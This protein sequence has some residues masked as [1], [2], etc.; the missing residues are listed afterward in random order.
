MGTAQRASAA[1]SPI[2]IDEKDGT[3][4]I[5]VDHLEDWIGSE[6]RSAGGDK[7][8]KI[9]DIHYAGDDAVAIVIRSG[10]GGRKHH[11]ASLKG[12]RAVRDGINLAISEDDLVTIDGGPL[13]SSQVG[14]LAV[15]D[16]RLRDVLPEQIESWTQ[17]EER[18]KQAEEVRAR[19]EELEA[20]ADRLA[21]EEQA[22]ASHASDAQS[23][24]ADLRREREEAEARARAARAELP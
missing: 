23:A 2:R 6:A 5:E 7:L 21:A 8:G 3:M 14:A 17:R 19:A 13:T 18:S 4:G 24:A 20:E 9:D 11:A 15:H 1:R 12:A 16:E 22:A 10:L